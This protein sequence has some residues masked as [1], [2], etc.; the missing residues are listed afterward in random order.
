MLATIQVELTANHPGSE[1]DA[2]WSFLFIGVG[3]LLKAQVAAAAETPGRSRSRARSTWGWPMPGGIRLV[4]GSLN[5]CH[6]F[7][8]T[9]PSR[10]LGGDDS[11]G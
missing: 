10:T 8:E 5:R 3:A 9:L 4:G 6:P 7:A 2:L 11:H 1:S